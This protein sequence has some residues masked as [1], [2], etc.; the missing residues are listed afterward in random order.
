MFRGSGLTRR[1]VGGSETLLNVDLGFAAASGR[2]QAG[3]EPDRRPAAAGRTARDHGPESAA[4]RRSPGKG[5]IPHGTTCAAEASWGPS[6]A[7]TGV[8]VGAWP[9]I[10]VDRTLPV[11][12]TPGRTGRQRP[13]DRSA[14]FRDRPGRSTASGARCRPMTS[15]KIGGQDQQRRH[16]RHQQPADHRPAER[17]LHLAAPLERQRHRHHADGHGAGGHQDRP[18]A[19]ARAVDGRLGRRARRSSSARS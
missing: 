12:A 16:G 1:T 19:V 13:A 3:Q 17:G 9:S 8:A 18:Q 4:H 15:A 7:G 11:L 2:G 5:V 14:R 10:R 6:S